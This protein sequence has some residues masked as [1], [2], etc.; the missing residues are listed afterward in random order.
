M[1][2]PAVDIIFDVKNRVILEGFSGFP[3]TLRASDVFATARGQTLTL[4]VFAVEPSEIE[5]QFKSVDISAET[6]QVGIARIAEPPQI[7][8]LTLSYD[9][10]TTAGIEV[11]GITANRI[12][13]AVNALS[14]APTG[15]FEVDLVDASALVFQ[16]SG[17]QNG[18]LS[19]FTAD[20]TNL[21]PICVANID[22]IRSG[23]ASE[24]ER[25]QIVVKEAYLA[26][27]DSGWASI[28]APAL[29]VSQDVTGSATSYSVQTISLSGYPAFGSFSL[30]TVSG[31]TSPLSPDS[32]GS[33]VESAINAKLGTGTVSVEKV[34]EFAWRVTYLAVGAQTALTGD[35]SGISGF[36]GRTGSFALNTDNIKAAL[37]GQTSI[38][39][40]FEIWLSGGSDDRPVYMETVSFANVGLDPDTN[41]SLTLSASLGFQATFTD[42]SARLAAIPARIGQLGVQVDTSALY[43]SSGTTAGDWAI[44]AQNGALLTANNLSDLDNAATARNNLGLGTAAVLDAGVLSGQV[45]KV[46]G[47]PLDTPAA[48]LDG[49]LI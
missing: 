40:E 9:G 2:V 35:A 7:G 42:D 4:N 25:Q 22:T 15:G 12:R 5:G 17:R 6:L 46:D 38:T 21:S 29:T 8:K 32:S 16:I 33:D 27:T 10:Q 20:V 39:A 49:G 45:F 1:S 24:K 14:S 28:V 41:T 37:G 23:S 36:A 34:S 26:N 31:V 3:R 43:I 47:T 44:Y 13:T 18:A 30:S 11:P 48:V 19:D